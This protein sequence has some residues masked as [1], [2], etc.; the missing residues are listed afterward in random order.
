MKKLQEE[1]F[2]KERKIVSNSKID[3]QIEFEKVESELNKR[4]K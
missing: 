3:S 4:I 1:I 2:E